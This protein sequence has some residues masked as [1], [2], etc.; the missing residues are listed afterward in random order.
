MRDKDIL[1]EEHGIGKSTGNGEEIIFLKVL[2]KHDFWLPFGLFF[3]L[4]DFFLPF[5]TIPE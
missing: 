3:F 1:P 5:L 4:S 2:N